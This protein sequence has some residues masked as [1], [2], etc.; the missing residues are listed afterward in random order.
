MRNRDS[1]A[2]NTYTAVH[3]QLHQGPRAA[4]G[5]PRRKG[6]PLPVD[7]A[8]QIGNLPSRNAG[9]SHAAE[10]GP[11]LGGHASPEQAR[12]GPRARPQA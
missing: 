11:R 6:N 12:V 4:M 9:A 1:L 8:A 7:L 3:P 10:R 5:T 2:A